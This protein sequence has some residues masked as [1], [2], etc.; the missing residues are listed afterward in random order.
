M[1]SSY[2]NVDPSNSNKSRFLYKRYNNPYSTLSRD[3]K[4]K[5]RSMS[6]KLHKSLAI[7]LA[8]V[9]FLLR[10]AN[11]ASGQEVEDER[12]FSYERG[13]D[14]GPEHW[15]EIHREWATCGAG[16]MQSPIDLANNQ[17]RVVAGLSQLR[18]AYGPA[19]AAMRN[20]GHD[21]EIKWEEGGGGMWVNATYY[22]LRQAHWHSPSEHTINGSRYAL[23]LH[24][25]HQSRDNKTAV[26][27]IVYTIGRPDSFI[28]R[29]EEFIRRASDMGGEEEE[30]QLGIV[31]ASAISMGSSR[32]S[33]EY[34]RYMGSYG[35]FYRYAS[36]D[37]RETDTANQQQND[38]LV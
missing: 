9:F 31:D 37:E 15:G 28:T 24:L 21:I 17:V 16:Q 35:V 6:M 33:E 4:G 10:T 23:E 12:E 32:N 11:Q 25:V 2:I 8:A 18:R 13:S 7:I 19:K 34:Y 3:R 36:G 27:G 20:R 5:R 22:V 26:V 38:C 30:V 14:I 1:V 29:M